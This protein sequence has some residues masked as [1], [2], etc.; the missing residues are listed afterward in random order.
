MASPGTK[1]K[2]SPPPAV[3][4]LET[5]KTLAHELRDW[6]LTP[7]NQQQSTYQPSGDGEGQGVRLFKK[8][9]EYFNDH[10]KFESITSAELLESG[11]VRVL[12][13]V[14]GARRNS[15]AS[16]AKYTPDS[17]V[18]AQ[19]DFLAAFMG[20]SE[21]EK[22]SGI[23]TPFSVLT[24]KLH[25]LLSRTE[26][27]EVI[28]T[29]GSSSPYSGSS[30]SGGIGG[31]TD[32]SY[33]RSSAIAMLA[34]Q[35]RIKLIAD[36]AGEGNEKEGDCPAIPKQ[37]RNLI[38]SI[39]AI[40][41]FKTLDDYLRPRL[42]LSDRPRR[43]QT[44]SGAGSRN[45]SAG[46]P[47][48][49]R[50]SGGSDLTHQRHHHRHGG[51]H[52][53]SHTDASKFDGD[54]LSDSRRRSSRRHHQGP[55]SAPELSQD[56]VSCE[57]DEEQLEC[58]DE[59]RL[60]EDEPDNKDEGKPEEYGPDDEDEDI[61]DEDALDALVDDFEGDMSDDGMP[62]RDPSAVNV[63]VGSSGSVTA[64]R[65]DGTRVS[66]PRTS[67]PAAAS[68]PT[69]A[70]PPNPYSGAESSAAATADRLL[71][72]MFGGRS[73]A[74]YAAALAAI[75][76]DWHLEFRM[77][78]KILR[79][80]TTIYRAVHQARQPESQDKNVFGDV[81][82]IHYRRVPGPPSPE[83][84][85]L[86]EEQ[87]TEER[88][89]KTDE[90]GMP[91]SL[92]Q[93]HTVASILQL[94]R[95]L[96]SMNSQLAD[97]QTESNIAVR[98]EPEALT[99]FINT[100]LTAKLNRQLEEP[101]IVASKCLP[102]WSED[103][104]RQFPFL[105]PFETRHMFLQSTSFGYSR[106]LMRWQQADDSRRDSRH[107]ESPVLGRLSRQ[108]VRISRSRILESAHKVMDLYGSSANVLEVEYFEEVGT[109]LGPT[110]EFYSTVSKEF[111]SKKLKMWRE[112]DSDPA[113]EYVFSKSG[114]FPAPMSPKD[115]RKGG[116]NNQLE[117]FKVLGKFVAR[118]M[119]DSR[120][121][122]V[123]FSATFFRLANQ[124]ASL[125]PTIG[126]IKSIDPTLA[127]SLLYIK[128]FANAKARIEQDTLLSSAEKDQALSEV[129]IDDARIE[130][131]GLDFTLP[132]YPNIDLVP[133]GSSIPLTLENVA[134]YLERVIDLTL[135]SGVVAQM[136][137]FRTGFS[138]VFPYSA[139]QSFTPD[140]LVMLFGRTE[141]DW[142]IETLTDSMKADH[143]FNMDSKSVR[144]LLQV[145]SEFTI[146]QRRDFLQF[147]TGSPKLP[148]GGFRSLTPIF[149][150][151]CRPSEPPFMPDDYLPSVMTCVNYLKLPDYSSIEVLAA[152]LNVAMSEGQGAFHLS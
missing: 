121:I 24:H 151:V 152:R 104:A 14:L 111:S 7:N 126:T 20:S 76:Q 117:G 27:F 98:L 12:L 148:I 53:K 28:T 9:A 18:D 37:Y 25:D 33:S 57:D 150:V 84:S 141:E 22:V 1:T 79:G 102:E 143:G 119:L 74:S 127:N 35:L 142:S 118:S 95:A 63:E 81:H 13:D 134:L 66:T 149:T 48:L 82:T 94:L 19:A 60:S 65:E 47:P 144:N 45:A 68:R 87:T 105:F 86:H 132:G 5:L 36:D 99:Q 114:L 113:S 100:K 131:L 49:A 77:N 41:N 43:S 103:L 136:Q 17:T 106:A 122:D 55:P 30:S 31:A 128:K 51:H 2:S 90:N 78:G 85:T 133:G 147:V 116:P 83:P 59:K 91:Q 29:G 140:E 112:Q 4:V 109:G 135:G 107:D 115:A 123:P 146:Q 138:E 54:E 56:E 62:P 10:D 120:I 58:A 124:S 61:D 67:T 137:A 39:H 101:L 50:G 92:L 3:Q 32:S 16:S 110:L 89:K 129:V 26:N 139:M 80:D 64:K 93:N 70:Q 38:V 34:K 72:G 8:L 88:A 44:G 75:P 6:Y 145:M 96:H 40:A 42:I 21:K 52:H 130:D 15:P 125:I 69:A 23:L 71:A 73:F 11:I 97:I 46:A 108:K